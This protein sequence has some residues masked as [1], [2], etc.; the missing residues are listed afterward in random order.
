MTRE[1]PHNHYY[2]FFLNKKFNIVE[3]DCD[4]HPPHRPTNYAINTEV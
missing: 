3:V 1:T 4:G 2:I